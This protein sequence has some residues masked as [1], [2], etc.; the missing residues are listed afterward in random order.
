MREPACLV[1]ILLQSLHETFG[2]TNSCLRM[3]I[4]SA[5]DG[6]LRRGEH[7][8]ISDIIELGEGHGRFLIVS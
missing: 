2:A 8:V 5:V 6:A 3:Q 1:A 4:R 7:L